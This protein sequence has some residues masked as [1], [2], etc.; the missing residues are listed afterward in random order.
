M[1]RRSSRIAQKK[2]VNYN[3]DAMFYRRTQ[4]KKSDW[5]EVEDL[6]PV[7]IRKKPLYRKRLEKKKKIIN[8]ASKPKKKKRTHIVTTRNWRSSSGM[9]SKSI[10]HSRARV[11][12]N[13]GS[14][15][16]TGG[17]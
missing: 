4:T 9:S 1:P 15:R 8:L 2:R 10:T 12:A 3:E 7:P 13:G 6:D 16:W 17:S 5:Q 11:S 14:R